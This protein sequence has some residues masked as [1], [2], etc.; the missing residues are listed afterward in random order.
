M[1][2]TRT[3]TGKVSRWRERRRDIKIIKESKKIAEEMETRKAKDKNLKT[4]AP[5][6]GT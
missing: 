4:D 6:T 1:V 3:V 5:A 2:I